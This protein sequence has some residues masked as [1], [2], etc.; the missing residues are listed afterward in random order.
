MMYGTMIFLALDTEYALDVDTDQAAGDDLT[1]F[2]NCAAKDGDNVLGVTGVGV[3]MNKIQ[4]TIKA[5]QEE[6]G[7]EI[8]LMS[9][10]GT[11]QIHADENLIEKK[12]AFDDEALYNVRYSI[13]NTKDSLKL[14]E[15]SSKGDSHYIVS[16]Y[17]EELDW[18]L[19]VHKNAEI[20]NT[21]LFTQRVKQT[22]IFFIMFL[23]AVL[24]VIYIT[25]HYHKKNIKLVKTDYLTEINNRSAFDDSLS[26]CI[27]R[28]NSFGESL[29]LAVIDIDN[30]KIINDIHGHI[31]G[32][33]ILKYVAEHLKSFIR[34]NDIIARWGGD[35]FAIIFNCDSE[36]TKKILQ[37]VV[38]N[39]GKDNLLAQYGVTFSI[40][41]SQYKKNEN[42]KALLDRADKA[43]YQAKENGKNQVFTL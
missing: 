21:L 34:S 3:K 1:L 30:F 35:E 19:I 12:N 7:V 4:D 2:V 20:L 38:K 25:G 18:Y 36:V 17:V 27:A 37:R 10:D 16:Y 9:P 31:Q 41:I 6:Y 39:R 22:V 29:T 26:D 8:F 28:A 5:Y 32:D 43:L 11:I 40:G 14:F 15:P 42:A 23:I 33:R 24:V 13:L